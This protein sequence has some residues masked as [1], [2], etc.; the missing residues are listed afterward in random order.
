MKSKV[1]AVCGGLHPYGAN[2]GCEGQADIA[3][4]SQGLGKAR[5]RKPS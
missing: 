1:S 4:D 3:G 2:N 5:T